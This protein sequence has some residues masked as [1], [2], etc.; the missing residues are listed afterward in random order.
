MIEP[1]NETINLNSL[2]SN[3]AHKQ[4]KEINQKFNEPR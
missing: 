3:S 1:F 2:I 4:N